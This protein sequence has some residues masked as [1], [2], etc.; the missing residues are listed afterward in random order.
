MRAGGISRIPRIPDPVPCLN[1]LPKL[2]NGFRQM[3]IE[4]FKRFPIPLSHD[5]GE[6]PFRPK[7]GPGPPNQP[8][9]TGQNRRS[10]GTS[11]IGSGVP[12]SFPK[13]AGRAHHGRDSVTEPFGNRPEY[14][15]LFKVRHQRP[16]FTHGLIVQGPTIKNDRRQNRKHKQSRHAFFS[17]GG[18][19]G[20][21]GQWI[22]SSNRSSS[23]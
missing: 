17:S 15:D 13:A 12:A 10:N 6:S 16:G 18:G 3:E 23:V 9:P 21:M 22:A 19:M 5:Q 1:R 4:V 20:F 14:F 2:K 7:A 11:E 8:I